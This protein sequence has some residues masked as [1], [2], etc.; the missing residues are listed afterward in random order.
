MKLYYSP[1]ACSLAPHIALRELGLPFELE[2][3]DLRTK[4][5]ESGKD[6][7]TVN[8]KGYVPALELDD[9]FV[10][11]EVAAVLQYLADLVPEKELAPRWGTRERYELQAWLHFVGSELHKAFGALF[12]PHT[13]EQK[14]AQLA[15]IGRRLD[16]V[17][18]E[19]AKRP[20]LV[21]D[22]YSVADIY[23]FVITSWS[24]RFGIDPTRWPALLA[25]RQRIAGR[26]AVLAA[27][28]AEKAPAR[29]GQPAGV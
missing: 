27:W 2:R 15:K 22:R 19:L 29:A 5:T 9:G 25:W 6:Y 24:E 17:E 10:L 11:T 3:V 7:W 28:E 26:P 4:R 20:W 8:P 18:T 16:W 12:A 21:G 23:L 14:E 13:E 1:R